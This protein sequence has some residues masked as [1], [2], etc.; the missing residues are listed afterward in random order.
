[1][2]E[3]ITAFIGLFEEKLKRLKHDLKEELKLAREDLKK[4]QN[5]EIVENVS[6][7]ECPPDFTC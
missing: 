3:P 6:T 2:K 4:K 7:H 5:Q 1:M